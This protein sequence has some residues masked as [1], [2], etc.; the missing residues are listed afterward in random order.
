[1]EDR[2]RWNDKYSKKGFWVHSRAYILSTKYNSEQ[3]FA[4]VMGKRKREMWRRKKFDERCGLKYKAHVEAHVEIIFKYKRITKMFLII[5]LKYLNNKNKINL[6][7]T[8]KLGAYS[9]N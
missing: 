6:E 8:S 2:G 9:Q 4:I 3:Q 5:E 7:I 1:M